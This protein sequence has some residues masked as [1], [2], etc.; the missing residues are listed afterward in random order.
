MVTYLL[1]VKLFTGDKLDELVNE[2]WEDL[3]N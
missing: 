2:F 1:L 3:A